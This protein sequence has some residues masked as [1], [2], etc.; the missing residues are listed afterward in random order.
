MFILNSGRMMNVG[1]EK[2]FLLQNQLNMNTSDVISTYV[3]RV[4]IQ[5]GQ[6]GLA[7]AVGL[8]NSLINMILILIVNKISS[9]L[10]ENSLW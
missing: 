10:S 3:Y 8:F 2:V 4:G 7:T 9:S 5:G 6:Y 1:F